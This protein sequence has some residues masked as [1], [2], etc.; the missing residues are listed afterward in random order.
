VSIEEGRKQNKNLELINQLKY[1]TLKAE[2][3]KRTSI[4]DL[5][6]ENNANQDKLRLSD[7]EGGTAIGL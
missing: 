3:T 1:L 6:D 5:I 2:A 4:D 7:E